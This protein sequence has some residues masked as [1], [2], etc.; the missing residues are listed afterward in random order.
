MQKYS[1]MPLNLGIT[2]LTTNL[3]WMD[4]ITEMPYLVSKYQFDFE[5]FPLAT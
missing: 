2:Q 5:T 3:K 1:R 4:M